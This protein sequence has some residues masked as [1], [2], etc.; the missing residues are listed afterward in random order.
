MPEPTP[1]RGDAVMPWPA[2]PD[3]VVYQGLPGQIVGELLPHTEAD[4]VG[5]LVTLLACA[6]NAMGN[7]PHYRVGGA[8]H[9]LRLFPVLVG[10]TSSGRKGTAVDTLTPIF[11][12]ALPDWWARRTKGMVSGEGLIYHVRDAVTERKPIKLKGGAIAGFE[13][14]TVD[15]GESE[16]RLL[17]IEKEF[18]G[19]LKVMTRESN[20]LSPVIRDAWDGGP[21]AT[22]SKNSATRATGAH[23]TILGHITPEELTENLTSTEA[24]NG[25]ANRF[26]WICVTRSKELPFGGELNDADCLALADV[27]RDA[28]E[29]GAQLRRITLSEDSKAAWVRVY[30]PLTTSEPGLIGTFLGRGAPYVMRMAAVYAALDASPQIERPHLDAALALW[31]YAETSVRHIFAPH[32]TVGLPAA[33]TAYRSTILAALAGGRLTQ[34]EISDDA[35]SGNIKAAEYL[36]V[37]HA[38]LMDGLVVRTFERPAS[39]R[40]KNITYW[41]LTEAGRREVAG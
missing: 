13:D 30:G 1:I 24:H 19:V 25:F 37:L 39:G 36:P 17:I 11:E 8:R 20:T 10:A 5:L 4:P 38:L 12:A 3:P 21:M 35:L 40:G 6:G 31:G 27:L 34:T 29:R 32:A 26:L 7:G 14:V 23:I 28:I 41:E 15:A 9:E 18:G 33:A 16:K 2:P 22:L